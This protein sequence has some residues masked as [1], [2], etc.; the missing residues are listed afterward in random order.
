M[1]V[2]VFINC[3]DHDAGINQNYEEFQSL[4]DVH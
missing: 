4:V 3:P 2:G 1:C